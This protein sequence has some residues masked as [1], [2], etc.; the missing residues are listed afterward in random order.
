MEKKGSETES[1]K[2]RDE[3]AVVLEL[4]TQNTFIG[5]MEADAMID[6]YFSYSVGLLSSHFLDSVP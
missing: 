4:V 2:R 1:K 5:F 3:W 6:V